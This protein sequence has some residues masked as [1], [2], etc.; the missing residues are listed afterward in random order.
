MY[1]HC[2][3]CFTGK[4][5]TSG[6]FAVRDRSSPRRPV[7]L[8]PAATPFHAILEL[9][10]VVAPGARPAVRRAGRRIAAG[11][12]RRP[13]RAP[14]VSS[15][16]QRREDALQ[17]AGDVADED[18][19]DPL[20]DRPCPRDLFDILAFPGELLVAQSPHLRDVPRAEGDPRPAASPLPLPDLGPA[21][22]RPR[23]LHALPRNVR[24]A[25]GHCQW[26]RGAARRRLVA[27]R[28]Q[29]GPPR[30][31]GQRCFSRGGTR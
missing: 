25:S 12:G 3:A 13:R 4:A 21:V 5:N 10:G 17:V 26:R 31:T 11:V 14:G 16:G 15:G 8:A 22:V 2:A 30:R 28:S 7:W 20:I 27:G 24:E 23:R 6:E 19:L 18:A 29:G 9:G 1:V